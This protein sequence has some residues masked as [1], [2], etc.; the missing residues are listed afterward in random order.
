MTSTDVIVKYA[1]GNRLHENRPAKMNSEHQ[2]LPRPPHG[3]YIDPTLTLHRPYRGNYGGGGGGVNYSGRRRRVKDSA[4]FCIFFHKLGSLRSDHSL[5]HETS[6]RV[7][8]AG[9]KSFCCQYVLS[10]NH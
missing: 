1:Y 3:P 8:S 9:R 10:D 2:T 4:L 5:R 7:S 6:E